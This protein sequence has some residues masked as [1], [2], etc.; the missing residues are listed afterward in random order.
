MSTVGV[1]EGGLHTGKEDFIFDMN[2]MVVLFI[3]S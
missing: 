1:P 2:E 3:I